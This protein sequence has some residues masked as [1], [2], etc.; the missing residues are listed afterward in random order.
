VE[1]L[2]YPNS[3]SQED[4]L[5]SLAGISLA[6]DK[7]QESGTCTVFDTSAGWAGIVVL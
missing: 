5:V 7:I 3:N 2:K 1:R 6:V 4:V